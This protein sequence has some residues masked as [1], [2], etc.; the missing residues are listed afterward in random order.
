MNLFL[1]AV[2]WVVIELV[3]GFVFGWLAR[4]RE[5]KKL[6]AQLDNIFAAAS[7]RVDKLER[8]NVTHADVIC[9]LLE[10]TREKEGC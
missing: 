4:G 3:I 8:S 2:L 7:D 1:L 5:V 9:S 10:K 6:E